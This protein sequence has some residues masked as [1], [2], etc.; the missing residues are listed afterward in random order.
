MTPV[1][2]EN[3][4]FELHIS[5]IKPKYLTRDRPPIILIKNKEMNLPLRLIL[6]DFINQML[7]KV[8]DSSKDKELWLFPFLKL[9]E[10][11]FH[12]LLEKAIAK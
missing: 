8:K 2:L 7:N 10:A 5:M 1:Y 6:E 3:D 12:Q 4:C 9:L 11:T